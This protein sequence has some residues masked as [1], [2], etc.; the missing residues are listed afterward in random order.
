MSQNNEQ[1]EIAKQLQDYLD[2]NKEK[3]SDKIY[4]KY[5]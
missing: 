2:E 4:K 3:L 5:F 1:L